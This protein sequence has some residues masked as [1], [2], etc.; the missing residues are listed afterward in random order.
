MAGVLGLSGLW[1]AGVSVGLLLIGIGGAMAAL[2][3]IPGNYFSKN[4]KTPKRELR[5]PKWQRWLLAIVKNLVGV[6]VLALGVVMIVT[7]GPG[8]VLLLL[9]LTLVDVPGKRKLQRYLVSRPLVL[10]SIN[11]LR[12]RWNR[13]ELRTS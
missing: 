5:R 8:V 10:R 13:P 2:V 6:A 12:A 9:G 4:R 7:P 11:K 3:M 1:M